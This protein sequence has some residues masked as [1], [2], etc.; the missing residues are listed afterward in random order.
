MPA[1]K[2]SSRDAMRRVATRV[3]IGRGIVRGNQSA[4]IEGCLQG[5]VNINSHGVKVLKTIVII[6]LTAKK[7]RDFR[8]LPASF[9]RYPAAWGKLG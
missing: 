1:V 5:G 8:G 7:P 6:V 9:A 3:R 2:E 4:P